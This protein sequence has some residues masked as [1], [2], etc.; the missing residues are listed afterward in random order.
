MFS[1]FLPAG[2]HA[3]P[4]PGEVNSPGA[5][6]TRVRCLPFISAISWNGQAVCRSSGCVV[7]TGIQFVNQPTIPH[8]RGRR[9][10][11]PDRADEAPADP[12]NHPQTLTIRFMGRRLPRSVPWASRSPPTSPGDHERLF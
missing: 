6:P 1:S 11:L 5:H 12:R 3:P 2:R 7:I 4:R 10:V 8:A 9:A